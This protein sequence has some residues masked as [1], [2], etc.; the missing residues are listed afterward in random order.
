MRPSRHLIVVGVGVLVAFSS[1]SPGASESVRKQSQSATSANDSPS[2]PRNESRVSPVNG[3]APSIDATPLDAVKFSAPVAHMDALTPDQR[4]DDGRVTRKTTALSNQPNATK[5]TTTKLSV[6]KPG[7]LKSQQVSQSS[8]ASSR[9]TAVK[10]SEGNPTTIAQT[11]STQPNLA[12]PPATTPASSNTPNLAPPPTT[13]PL[14]QPTTPDPGPSKPLGPA[15]PGSAPDYLNPNPNPLSFP[16]K[17]SEV[18]LQ[19]IQPITLQQAIELA[20]RNNRSLQVSRLQ[21][22]RSRAS[23]RQAQAASY[24]TLSVQSTI[25]RSRSAS[26]NRQNQNTALSSLLGV[27]NNADTISNTFSASATL[28]YDIFTSGKRPANIR[29]AEQQLRSDELQVEINQEQ[30]RLDVASDYYNLQQGDESVR[31]NQSAVR[32]NEFSLRDTEALER[33]GLGTRFD[34]LQAQVQLANSRQNLTNA[35]AQQEIYRRQLAQRLSITP[36]IDLAAADP[37]AVAGDWNL[38]LEESIILALKNRAELEQQLAQREQARQQRQAALADIRPTVTAQ[39]QY[40]LSDVLD[41]SFPVGDG[42][43]FSLGVNW[44]LFDGGA[45][46]ARARQAEANIAIAEQNFADQSNQI[47]F[48]V[49]QAYANLLSNFENIGTTTQG[50]DQA[51]ESLRLAR[52]RFQAGV[53]TQTDVINA[54]NALTQAEGNRVNAILGYN[55]ALASLQRAITNLPIA[56][57]AKLPS[58]TVPSTIAPGSPTPSPATPGSPTPNSPTPNSTTPSPAT[59]SPTTP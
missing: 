49:E 21:L 6:L 33:A 17:P 54:E 30:L 13:S 47:R 35:I 16:T 41:D 29:A 58:T 43:A 44:N 31:I 15:K 53:G 27:N 1:M 8:L 7:V 5:P 51:R 56:T 50:L 59:P 34:V 57:G 37:V 48:A 2:S 11:T 42:Y 4:P 46:I 25:S 14:P 12:S 3:S 22:E 10:M 38:S 18:K 55:R 26:S 24:P 45:A 32:N 28:S 36:G 52:L 40:S 19:G 20:V 23:L 39:A 9:T